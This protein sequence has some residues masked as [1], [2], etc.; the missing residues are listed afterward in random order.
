M[1]VR[2]AP[3]YPQKLLDRFATSGTPLPAFR[4]ALYGCR[5]TAERRSF[6]YPDLV[7]IYLGMRVRTW[8]GLETLF[9]FGP[10]IQNSVAQ[11]PNG[12]LLH[13]NVVYSLIPPRAGMRQYR[14]DF[15]SLERCA[16]SKP[17]QP[18]DIPPAPVADV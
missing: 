4:E 16:R 7:V 6:S 5:S 9:G 18:S 2:I 15:D 10:K 8:T 3:A 1:R 14:S 17:H 12:L 13:E 11:K